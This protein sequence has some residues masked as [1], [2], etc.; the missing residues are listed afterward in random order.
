MSA[1][2][3]LKRLALGVSGPAA[4]AVLAVVL[5]GPG[6]S[7]VTTRI[8]VTLDASPRPRVEASEAPPNRFVG[9]EPVSHDGKVDAAAG[10]ALVH[11]AGDVA[12]ALAMAPAV[13]MV[14]GD[15]DGSSSTVVSVDADGKATELGVLA[16][17]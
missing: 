10:P 11:A 15:P 17:R 7:E 5:D 16:H 8:E 4:L 14:V 9:R 3:S 6:A 1:L 13:A 12:S 2:S